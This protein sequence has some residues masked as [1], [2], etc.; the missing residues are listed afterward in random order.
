MQIVV[1]VLE[2]IAKNGNIAKVK[3]PLASIAVD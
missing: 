1:T 3:C 2:K